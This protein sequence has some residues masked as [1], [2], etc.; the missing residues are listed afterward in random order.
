LVGTGQAQHKLVVGTQ[1]LRWPR[2]LET[3]EDQ[4]CEDI[5][6]MPSASCLG[7]IMAGESLGLRFEKEGE[8]PVLAQGVKQQ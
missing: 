5:V 7:D 4:H 2:Q 8:E 3:R 6:G 1:T